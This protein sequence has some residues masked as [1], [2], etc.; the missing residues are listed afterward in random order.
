MG[1]SKKILR[2]NKRLPHQIK[3][4]SYKQFNFRLKTI[5][6]RKKQKTNFVEETIKIKAEINKKET[7]KIIEMIN[8]T[9]RCSFEK[10]SKMGGIKV[11]EE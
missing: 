4:I 2:G 10:I 5:R 3:K 9:E 11:T 7:K 8:E 1:G 6:E